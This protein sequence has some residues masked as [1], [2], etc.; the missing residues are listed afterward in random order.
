MFWQK[1]KVKQSIP[2]EIVESTRVSSVAAKREASRQNSTSSIGSSA[3]TCATQLSNPT[4]R[5]KKLNWMINMIVETIEENIQCEPVTIKLKTPKVR[6]LLSVANLLS[7][8]PIILT[9]QTSI[10]IIPTSCRLTLSV[11]T[12]Q[13]VSRFSACV[14]RVRTHTTC[15]ETLS[16]SHC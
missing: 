13:F 10:S 7:V 15:V 2:E 8:H 14:S 12:Y 5:R 9:R 4:V 3:D 1:R 11:E 6:R 16:T